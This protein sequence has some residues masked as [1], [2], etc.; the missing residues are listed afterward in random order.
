[1]KSMRVLMLLLVSSSFL[2]GQ[3]NFDQTPSRLVVT[4]SVKTVKS[5]INSLSA[6]QKMMAQLTI[7]DSSRTKWSNLPMESTTRKGIQFKDLTDSQKMLIHSLL[8]LVLSQQ[9]YQKA[10]FIIQ[11][12]QAILERLSKN[13]SPIAHRYGNQ[14]Y[15][16]SVFGTPELGQVWGWKFEGHHLSINMTYSSKGVT[17]TPLFVGINPALTT[18]GA[19]AGS[20]VMFEENDYGNQLFNSLT[21]SLKQKAITMPLPKTAD[22]M[23]QLGNEPHLTEQ[24]G[25][26]FSEMTVAQQVLVEKIAR[27]WIENFTSELADEK[28]KQFHAQ[29]QDIWF[30]WQGTTNT[31]ELHYYSIHTKTFIIEHCHRDQGIYHYHTLWRDLTEDYKA[32]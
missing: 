17:C 7:A 14:N 25:V 26:K 18:S 13:N 28:L 20:Y 19:Y 4:S 15:W 22:V 24:K 1:M 12:D 32:K 21:E 3:N 23:T 6:Q 2:L 5:I 9:G 29:K 11:Y 30:T 16:F 8:R 27:T 10:L 31:A